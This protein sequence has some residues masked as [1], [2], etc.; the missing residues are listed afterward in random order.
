M[1]KLVHRT[2]PTSRIYYPRTK[3]DEARLRSKWIDVNGGDTEMKDKKCQR[4]KS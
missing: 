2:K 3:S 1:I 4:T